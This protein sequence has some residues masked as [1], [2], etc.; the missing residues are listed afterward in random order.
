MIPVRWIDPKFTTPKPSG[1]LLIEKTLTT[2]ASTSSSPT[3]TI[4]AVYP[5]RDLGL[6]FSTRKVELNCLVNPIQ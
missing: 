4:R 5:F 1:N 6:Q 3:L 2:S